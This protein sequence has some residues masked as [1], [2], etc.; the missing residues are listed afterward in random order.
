MSQKNTKPK[1]TPAQRRAQEAIDRVSRSSPEPTK[2]VL[3]FLLAG[4]HQSVATEQ[5]T[6]QGSASQGLETRL[7]IG[8]T[9]EEI[10]SHPIPSQV[11]PPHPIPPH[12]KAV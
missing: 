1:E 5:T 11:N 2:R 10:P 3:D 8:R 12:P 6:N 7:P 4:S 9:R